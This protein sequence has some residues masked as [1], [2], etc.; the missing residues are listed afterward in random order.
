[1]RHRSLVTF[2]FFLATTA[3]FGGMTREQVTKVPTTTAW[4]A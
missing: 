1:M 3:M 2:A 4:R